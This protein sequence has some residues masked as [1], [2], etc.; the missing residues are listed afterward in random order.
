MPTVTTWAGSGT[1]PTRRS[2]T[3]SRLL[4]PRALS[5]RWSGWLVLLAPHGWQSGPMDD[6]GQALVAEQLAD[7]PAHAPTTTATWPACIR[8]GPRPSTSCHHRGRARAGLR[9]RP[10]DPPAGRP[11]PLGDRPRRRPR[12]AGDGPPAG[13]GSAG[14]A[15]RGGCVRLGAAAPLRHGGFAFWLP[16][17]LPARFTAFWSMVGAALAAGGQVWFLDDTD[18]GGAGERVV[19][20][21]ATPAVWRRLRDGGQHRVVKVYY[22]PAELAARLAELGW[23]ASISATSIPLLVGTAR[24]TS[25]PGRHA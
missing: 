11:G 24:R 13:R 7:Y 5:H 16:H 4:P 19:A 3:Q 9:Q 22:S 25:D 14:G 18:R 1:A 6:D 17:V 2:G 12:D 23:S 10:L 8:T 15:D 20:D 21:Q